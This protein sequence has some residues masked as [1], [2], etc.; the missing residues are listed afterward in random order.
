MKDISYLYVVKGLG[1][2]SI[3]RFAR[4]GLKIQLV[5]NEL[6]TRVSITRVGPLALLVSSV[7]DIVLELPKLGIPSRLTRDFGGAQIHGCL[8]NG[9]NFFLPGF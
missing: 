7:A 3:P 2:P 1:P 4:V 6:G 9:Y 8:V 5:L